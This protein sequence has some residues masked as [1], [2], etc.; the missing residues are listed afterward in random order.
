MMACGQTKAVE[1]EAAVAVGLEGYRMV[2]ALIFLSTEQ[3]CLIM[4]GRYRLGRQQPLPG[5]SL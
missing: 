2:T 3:V 5:R 1:E 4:P